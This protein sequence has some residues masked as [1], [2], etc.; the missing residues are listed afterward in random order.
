MGR[1]AQR[2]RAEKA[3]AKAVNDI[4]RAERSRPTATYWNGERCEARKV[5]LVV[6]DGEHERGWYRQFIG[7]RRAAVEVSYA[8][9]VFYLDD[10]A[11]DGDGREYPA[12]GGWLKVTEGHGGPRWGHRSLYPEPGAGVVA[13]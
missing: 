6:A 5:W 7:Q 11:Y 13:R 3:T 1:N 12:G 9:Q 4:R 8:G 10:D 2:R